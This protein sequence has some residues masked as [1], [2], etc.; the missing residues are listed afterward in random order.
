MIP[1]P[2]NIK[3]EKVVKVCNSCNWLSK[4]F[5]QALL[6]GDTEKVQAV[7]STGNVNLRCAF[8][9]FKGESM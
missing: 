7:Y 9:N 4:A 1:D 8:K 6:K 5:K 2:Y 3:K